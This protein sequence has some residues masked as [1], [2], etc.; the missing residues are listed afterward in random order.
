MAAPV[1]IVIG[2]GAIYDQ[3]AG[4]PAVRRAFVAMTA[5]AAGYLLSSAVKIAAPLR[6][7]PVAI[8]MAICTFVAV[9]VLRL[10]MLAVLPVMAAVS[11][12]VLARLPA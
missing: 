7:K 9:A 12:V 5:A 2:L 8:G 3:Y 4:V 6:G 11:S 10:P 1:A